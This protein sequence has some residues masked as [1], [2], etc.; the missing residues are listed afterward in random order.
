MPKQVES[1]AYST[2]QKQANH[3]TRPVRVR[4]WRPT[5]SNFEQKCPRLCPAFVIHVV[6]FGPPPFVSLA[7]SDYNDEWLG[8][9]IC[10]SHIL[11]DRKWLRKVPGQANW[12][13]LYGP[14]IM[15]EIIQAV[16]SR[17]FALNWNCFQSRD[18]VTCCWQIG[19]GLRRVRTWTSSKTFGTKWSPSSERQSSHGTPKKCRRY[20]GIPRKWVWQSFHC[21]S[22]QQSL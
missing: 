18:W 20:I 5:R 9:I 4:V 2:T 14:T 6:T 10:I 22:S 12:V 16:E 11:D 8:I 13:R 1:G 7:A 21:I 17:V 15:P 19:R 3:R